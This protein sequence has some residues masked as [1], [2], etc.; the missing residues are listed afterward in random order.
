MSLKNNNNI[1]KNG[2]IVFKQTVKRIH[3]F[4]IQYILMLI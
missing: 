4:K 2:L 3:F 1:F